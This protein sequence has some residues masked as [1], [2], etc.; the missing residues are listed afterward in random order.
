MKISYNWLK[1]FL[2]LNETPEHLA[3]VLT[4]A[5]LEVESVE[6]I[7]LYQGK[8]LNNALEGL[9]IGEVLTCEKHPNADKLSKT[10]VSVGSETLPIVCGASNVAQ[11]QKVV[12]ATVGT[13]LYP[14]TGEPFTIK[15]AKIRGEESIGMI[16]AEDEIGIGESH[17]GIIVLQT[18]LP[19]GTPA[20]EFFNIETDYIFEIGLTPN[21]IDAASH[22]GVARDL[23]VLLQKELCQPS[24][25]QFVEGL[26]KAIQVIV[27]DTQACPRYAGILIEGVSVQPSPDWLKNRLKAIG[28][29]PINNVVDITNYVLHHLGQPLHAFDADCIAGGKIIV[30]KLAENTPFVTLDGIERKLSAQDLMI[31][32]TEKPLA[33]AGVFGGLHSG[34]TENTTKIFLESAYFHP[35]T[36]RKT[37]QRHSLKTDASFRFERGTDPNMPVY[38]LKFASILISEVAGGKVASEIID[39]YPQPITHFNFEVSYKNLDR[40]IGKSLDRTLIKNILKGL[41][42]K[43]TNETAQG[44]SVSVPPYRVDVRKEAD[45]VE[46][47]LRIYG[48]NNIEFSENLS[49]SFIASFPKTD[50]HKLQQKIT[51]ILTANAFNEI[52][53]NSLTK[54]EYAQIL[55]N[56]DKSQNVVILNKLSEELEVLRQSLIFSGLEAIS[57]NLNR[58]Q[59]DIKIFEFGKI[60]RKKGSQG[61]VSEKYEEQTQLALW[62]TGNWNAEGWQHSPAPK[63]TFHHLYNIVDKILQ[64]LKVSDV[65]KQE[66]DERVFAYGLALQKNDKIFAQIGELQPYILKTADLKG[67]VFYAELDWDWLI[68]QYN[69]EFTYQEIPKFP[70]VRRDLSLVLDKSV[71]YQ[72]VEQKAFALEKKLLKAVNIF[73]VYEGEQIGEGKKSYA[74]SFILQDE[75]QTLTESQIDKTMQKLMEGFRKDLGAVIRD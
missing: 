47:I 61:S 23:K 74:V 52:I 67:S 41:E 27:E 17:E 72:E 70:E 73:S 58:K 29:N 13:T 59:R 50:K 20:T 49:A 75:T 24:N 36:I 66:A 60:Y 28:L 30:K 32:D 35:D 11:G 37:A 10:T 4:Q 51:E 14:T 48:F 1:T 62:V 5:G 56:I 7:Y 42:I 43:I 38:A 6:K 44:F 18:D 34:V 54:P 31:C 39:I 64:S 25:A 57:Y 26:G 8:K 16:C 69:D 2:D 63:T 15:K 40:L 46:E 71:S 21:R 68:A 55:K 22:L 33:L 53:T 65:R 9:V 19:N 3:Q 45:I 12:V